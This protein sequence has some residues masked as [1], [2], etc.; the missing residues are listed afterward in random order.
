MLGNTYNLLALSDIHLGSDLVGHA[1]PEAPPRTT[2][3]ERR[4]RALIELFDWYREHRVGGQPWRLVIGGDFIDFTGMSVMPAHDARAELVTEPTEEELRHGLGG[5]ADHVLAKLRLVMEHHAGVM[6]ALGRFIAEDNHLVIVPGNH[7][8]DWHWESVQAAFRAAL[9]ERAGG[10]AERIEFSP[11]FYYEEGLIYLEHGH[12]YDGYCSHD[13]VLYPVLPSDPRRTTLSLSDVLVRCVVRPTRGMT[14]TGHDKMSVADYLRFAGSLGFRGM[15]KLV[16]CFGTAIR[17]ALRLWR[18]HV[19]EAAAWVRR[20][21]ERKMLQLCL[22]REYNIER[23]RS[24][25]HLHHPPLTRSLGAIAA[26]LM[27]DQVAL[28]IAVVAAAGCV[29]VWLD[30]LYVA[31]STSSL[32]IAGLAVA[33]HVWLRRASVEPSALLRERS[34]GVARLFPAQ[35]VVMGHTHVPEV[36]PIA[37]N[38][39][40]IN[41]GAWADEDVPD[42]SASSITRTHLVVTRDAAGP[43]ARLFTW[44]E[45]GPEPFSTP[46]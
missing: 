34:R 8:V 6:D 40:Y 32:V 37:E 45:T 5:A 1:R 44:R 28:A 30:H 36:Q 14:E 10:G 4:D 43:R 9:A 21:H 33:R 26:G 20:E 15:A 24:L 7:D 18:E 39:T 29:L 31:S 23:L 25:A 35:V 12:Q 16:R 38:S 42:G 13:Y 2:A 11:W 46:T 41:L 3:S 19:S 27:L 17:T 22:A